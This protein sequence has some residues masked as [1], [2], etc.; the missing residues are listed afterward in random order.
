MSGTEAIGPLM[1]RRPARLKR[2]NEQVLCCDRGAQTQDSG[3]LRRGGVGRYRDLVCSLVDSL[4]SR[5]SVRSHTD[6]RNGPC[7]PLGAAYVP[8]RTF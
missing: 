2:V 6:H 7:A 3:V 1:R 8:R 5:Q 4:E